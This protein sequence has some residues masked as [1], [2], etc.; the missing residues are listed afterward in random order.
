MD[1]KGNA[2]FAFVS[3]VCFVVNRFGEMHARV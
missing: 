2:R 1:T 3:F